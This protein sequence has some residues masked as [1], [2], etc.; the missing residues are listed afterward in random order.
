MFMVLARKLKNNL[1]NI[2]KS[3]TI[4]VI[5]DRI[6]EK[7]KE[8]FIISKLVMLDILEEINSEDIDKLYS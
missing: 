1:V 8:G 5:L 6:F 7:E 2:G 3:K 4:S